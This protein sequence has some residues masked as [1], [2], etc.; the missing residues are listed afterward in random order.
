MADGTNHTLYRSFRKSGKLS[1]ANK[2]GKPQ[3]HAS[4]IRM[5]LID[6]KIQ[7][8]HFTFHL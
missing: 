2:A 1:Y 5:I 7:P 3:S 4:V 6:H 8:F